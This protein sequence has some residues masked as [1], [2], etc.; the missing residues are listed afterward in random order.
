[1][2][3]L[4]I[5][6]LMTVWI[7]IC[8]KGYEIYNIQTLQAITANYLT[9]VITGLVFTG[10]EPF[11][12]VK[13]TYQNWIFI[14]PFLGI[15]FIS[16]FYLI[17][18]TTQKIG[19]SITTLVNRISLIIPLIF[20][21][22]IFKTEH[23]S[24]SSFNYLGL[25]VAFFSIIISSY[26][27]TIHSRKTNHRWMLILVFLIGG[28]IDTTLNYSNIHL[29][30][31]ADRLIFPIIVFSTAF[32]GGM[33]ALLYNYVKNNQHIEHK[34]ILAGIILG[35]PNYF[36]IYFIIQSL[37]HYQNNGAF[38]FPTFNI[39]VLILSTVIGVLFFREKLRPWNY[40]GMILALGGLMLLME[41]EIW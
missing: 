12:A 24:F 21:L 38:V 11:L 10:L 23:R 41:G 27:K 25:V 14:P 39:L 6:V 1:M 7:F 22:F 28:L 8:F 16:G 32:L 35:V 30:T 26:T 37:E 13:N 4:F 17:S 34:N 5:S 18:I 40:I 29:K 20:S 31:E 15:G 19:M 36:S 33:I 2:S 9:C 3:Y